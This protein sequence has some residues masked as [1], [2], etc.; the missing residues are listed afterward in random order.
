MPDVEDLYL[1]IPKPV[2]HSVRKP[3]DQENPR[4]EI[5]CR[6]DLWK[7]GK[8]LYHLYNELL[9]ADRRSGTLLAHV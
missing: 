6:T 4:T 2:K 9:D 1:S 7:V 5:G 8:T 3:S